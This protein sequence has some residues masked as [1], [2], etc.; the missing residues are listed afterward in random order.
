MKRYGWKKTTATLLTGAMVCTG[1]RMGEFNSAFAANQ[2]G[3]R[4]V[5]ATNG[6]SHAMVESGVLKNV[7][8]TMLSRENEINAGSEAI[9]Q[10]FHVFFIAAGLLGIALI[11]RPYQWKREKKLKIEVEKIAPSRK[12]ERKTMR[13]ATPHLTVID[14]TLSSLSPLS[15]R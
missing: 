2:D 3:N 6:N 5:A 10:L 13:R 9:P 8:T 12:S 1:L 11:P 15:M 4:T 7:L 14:T